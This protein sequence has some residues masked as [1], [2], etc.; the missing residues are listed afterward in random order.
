MSYKFNPFT[1]NFDIVSGV[2]SSADNFSYEI[3][4][5]TVTIPYMQQ[6]M[7]YDGI[8]IEGAGSLNIEGTLILLEI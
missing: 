3:V 7:L 8:E 5:K 1:I 2:S 6:M 4:N